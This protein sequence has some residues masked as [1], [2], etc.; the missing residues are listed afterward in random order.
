VSELQ[1]I[2][3][4]NFP[5][6][7]CAKACKKAIDELGWSIVEQGKYHIVIKEPFFNS[8]WGYP[9]TIRITLESPSENLTTIKYYGANFGFGATSRINNAISTVH[10]KLTIYALSLAF[11]YVLISRVRYVGG[12]PL[13]P[14]SGP[15]IIAL[16]NTDFVIHPSLDSSSYSIHLL[17]IAKVGAGKP[18]TAREVYSEE[19]GNTIDVI[20]GSL[21]LSIVFELDNYTYT[22]SFEAFPGTNPQ[23]WVNQITVL[24]YQ[25]RQKRMSEGT[26]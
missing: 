21:F 18:K 16:S 12:H 9:A 19:G 6:S 3:P 14:K 15:V 8:L 7:L 20:E 1:K 4:L 26:S 17:K 5:L 22:A 13:M 23:E 25:L 11:G 2:F 24:Q 10:N